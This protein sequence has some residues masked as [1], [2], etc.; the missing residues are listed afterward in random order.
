MEINMLEIRPT[1]LL[2]PAG[3]FETFKAVINAGAD[4]VYLG[5][6]MFG[7]RAY[8]DNFTEEQLISAID[9]A[10][11]HGRKVYLTVNTLM[12]NKEIQDNLYN[13]LRPLYN[14][15][16]DAVIVQDYGALALIHSYFPDMEIHASTQMTVTSEYSSDLLREYGVTRIVP[17]REL[18]LN[19]IRRIHDYSGLEIECFVHGAI[20]YCYS[21]QCLLSSFIGGRSG[22]RGRCAQ[23][24]RLP[25][26]S[27]GVKGNLL[28]LK[29]M[30]TLKLLPEI[31]EAGVY[32]L[33]IEGRMKSAEYAAGVTSMYRKYLDL[34][35]KKGREG[36]KVSDADERQLNVLFDRGGLTEGYYKKHNGKDMIALNGT[37]GRYLDSKDSLEDT[38]RKEYIETE[39]KEKVNAS[40][41]LMKN[42]NA[43]MSLVYKDISISVQGNEVFEAKNKPMSQDDISKQILKTGG[44]GFEI[45]NLDITMSD[46]IFIPNK[47]LNDLRRQALERLT[48]EILVKFKR[49]AADH[50][51]YVT[52]SGNR[53]VSR[54]VSVQ[55]CNV[56]QFETV[57]K[58][59]HVNR[60][61][62][63]LD[64]I[65]VSELPELSVK[66]KEAGKLITPAMPYIFREHAQ[67][68]F[69]KNLDYLVKARPD[70]ILVRNI[71]EAGF[72][73]SNNITIP[74]ESDYNV[75]V[76]NDISREVLNKWGIKNNTV[77]VEL[78]KKEISHLDNTNS[79]MIVYGH[80]PLMVSAGCILKTTS[81]CQPLDKAIFRT[82]TDRQNKKM[83][84]SSICRFCYNL[85]YNYVP[86]DLTDKWQEIVKCG[87]SGVRICLTTENTE[88]TDHILTRIKSGYVDGGSIEAPDGEFTR[89]HFTR[90][91]E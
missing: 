32:S 26:E 76:M 35:A 36:Y 74:L 60:I 72:L 52:T 28:S 33:K 87:I 89:G 58:Y 39:I 68:Y 19:E 54:F 31:I 37:D 64:Y 83:P 80:L 9:M 18:N 38:I 90:G 55:V 30:C 41:T 7:A 48:E 50:S 51:E 6:N 40:V 49:E 16:L 4:A 71:E 81:G 77:P 73:K 2:A 21:G 62:I 67:R 20:C 3:S 11:L 85:I 75:Y 25:Y 53:S 43:T 84:F 14:A 13:Y 23:P 61:I 15:G 66:A 46:N 10:H 42:S 88:E 8:A 29:D 22:N 78:N 45:E 34:Y 47:S 79:E 17:A 86:V 44:T 24:C 59:D 1:E 65:D 57:L 70:S 56:N 91:I 27:Q 5:G 63:S 12:K 82:I 69:D